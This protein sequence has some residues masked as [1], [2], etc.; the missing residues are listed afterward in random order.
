MPFC[1]NCQ[2]TLYAYPFPVWLKASFAALLALLAFALWHGVPYFTAG[3]HL[4]QAR[5]A[6]DQ[7]DYPAAT[8]H[9]A[10][11]LSVKPTDQE[12]VLLGAK[13]NLMVGE[14]GGASSF[15]K[16]RPS[17]EN[18]A[19]FTE[20]NALWDHATA[21]LAKGDSAAKLAQADRTAVGLRLMDEAAREY[22]QSRYL[23]V[24]VL[25]LKT[26][27]AYERKDYDAMLAASRKALALMPDHPRLLSSVAS[28]L[29]CKFAVTGDSAFHVEAEQLL[30]RAEPLAVVSPEEKASFDEYAERIRYRLRA[31][32]IIDKAEYDRRFRSK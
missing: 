15:L 29:A 16:L 28:A 6:L 23:A 20:V 18:N 4:A 19:L 25:T 24:G 14:V 13:A 31:R 1:V 32:V 3:R 17:F 11:V 2:T 26:G 12:V 7:N 8:T 22:P 5:R 9:F 21:A 30:M 10:G 27:A